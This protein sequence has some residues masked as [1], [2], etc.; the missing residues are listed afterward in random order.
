MCAGE[1][2]K[3]VVPP[4]FG[5]GEKGT[6]GGIKGTF[7]PPHSTL[8]FEVELVGWQEK[9]PKPNV[10]NEMDT[11]NSGM[12]SYE[13]MTHWFANKHPQKLQSIPPGVWERDDKNQDGIIS[14]DEFSGPKGKKAKGISM[15]EL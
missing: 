1:K 5:Y 11:D 12:I 15:E 4:S 6:K 14:W 9:I 8:Q 13:E 7:L 3:L 2:R 10:F